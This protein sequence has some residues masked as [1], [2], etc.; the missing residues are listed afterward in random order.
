MSGKER[1]VARE[2]EECEESYA[3]SSSDEDSEESYSSSCSDEES[4]DSY[5]SP[6]SDE[7][8]GRENSAR[9]SPKERFQSLQASLKCAD[10]CKQCDGTKADLVKAKRDNKKLA[11]RNKKL[12]E[13]LKRAKERE[14]SSK[15]IKEEL[16]RAKEREDKAGEVNDLLNCTICFQ[17]W[18]QSGEHNFCSLSCGH[19]F[20][21]SCITKWI[22][23]NGSCGPSTIY[24]GVMKLAQA[25]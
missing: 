4:E 21:R 8:E 25:D 22:S 18:T 2:D 24:D 10:Y 5:L 1:P 15:K 23:R 19:F 9:R 6:S 7:D 14:E 13:E 20:G 12:E 17:P 3:S 16:K 11:E